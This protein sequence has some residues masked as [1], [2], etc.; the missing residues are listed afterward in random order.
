LNRPFRKTLVNE[1][2]WSKSREATFSECKRRYWFQYY[3]SWGGWEAAAGTRC[4]DIYILK[5]LAT[6]QQWAGTVVH[7]AIERSLKNHRASP[8]P[9]AVDVDEIVRITLQQM[10]AGFKSSREGVY[11]ARPKSCALFEHEYAVPVPDEEWGRTA[12]IVERCL[13]TFYASAL[14]ARILDLRREDW[15]EIEE[16]S[17]FELEGVKILVV[18]DF[19]YRLGDTIGIVDWKTGSSD[20]RDNRAQ[21]SCYAAYAGQKWSVPPEKVRATEF[22]LNRNELLE[23]T[24]SAEDIERTLDFIRG[25]A[26]DMKRLLRDPGVNVALEEDFPKVDDAR[27]CRRCSY[28]RVCEPNVPYG[29]ADP[30]PASLT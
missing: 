1:F 18:L 22:N 25:S 8:K 23:H 10:R 11:R 15:L 16:R 3:G 17:S 2:S 19:C 30:Y 29:P 21:L 5:Q 26:G 4:R 20:E 28:F 7:E 14:Y 13:R 27:V 12:E 24:L 9:L 6:R